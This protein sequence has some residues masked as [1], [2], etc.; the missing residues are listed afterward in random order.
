MQ[1]AASRCIIRKFVRS[2]QDPAHA[3]FGGYKQSGFGRET[4]KM[5]LDHYQQTKNLLVS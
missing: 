3:A 1:R 2:P 4:H 5:I